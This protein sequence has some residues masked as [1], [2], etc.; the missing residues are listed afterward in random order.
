[1]DAPNACSSKAP[2][3]NQQIMSCLISGSMASTPW[4]VKPPGRWWLLVLRP[5]LVE[6]DA[7]ALRAAAQQHV[8]VFDYIHPHIDPLRAGLDT[9]CFANGATLFVDH[10]DGTRAERKGGEP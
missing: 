9:H 4:C 6:I 8:A 3:N 2:A 1:M 7:D 10:G 5:L